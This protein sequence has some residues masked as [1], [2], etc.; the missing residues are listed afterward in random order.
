[1]ISAKNILKGKLNNPI[2]KVYP[3]L[4]EKTVIPTKE[5]QEIT[6]DENIYGLSKVTVESIPDNYNIT[7]GTLDINNNGEYN[8]K[9]KEKVNVD[10][11]VFLPNWKEIGY[12]NTPQTIIDDFNYSKE[13]Y[14]NWDNSL[15]NLTDKFYHDSFMV[16]APLVDTKNAI[17]MNSMF[18]DCTNLK[19]VPL[20]NTNNVKNMSNMFRG[21]ISL[22]NIESFDTSNVEDMRFMFYQCNIKDVPLFNM[23]SCYI[24]NNMFA[25]C[26]KLESIP[27]LNL[28]NVQDVRAMFQYSNNLINIP[29]FNLKNV[30]QINNMFSRL[31]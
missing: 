17:S 6:P 21:C 20:L 18:R 8:V 19:R 9:N 10:I 14:N 5:I 11:P 2:Q 28:E 25:Y 1:M 27:L 12:D 31:Q 13:I 7:E 15:T 3:E 4:Q 16:Y 24:T 22:E 30:T 26:S 23:K 29:I